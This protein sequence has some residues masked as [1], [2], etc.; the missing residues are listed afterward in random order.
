[1]LSMSDTPIDEMLPVFAGLGV[2]VAFL[3]PTP[4]GYEKAIMDA[5]A[6]VRE[7]LLDAGIHNYELQQQGPEGKVKISAHFVNL[8]DNT[9]TEASLYRP[10]TKKGDPRIWFS[11]LKTY[12]QPCNLLA[13]IVFNKELYVFNLS[14]PEIKASILYSGHAYD[15]LRS[16][17]AENEAVA[18]ELLNKIRKIHDKGFIPSITPGD[19]GVGDTLEH[20]LGISRNN[21][22]TPDYKG[23]ELKTTRLTRNGEARASTRSTL[24]TRVPDEGMTYREI[25]DNYGKWQTPR[26]E[27]EPR[28]QMYETLRVSRSNAYDLQLAV[29]ID[30]DE[31]RIMHINIEESNNADRTNQQASR[32]AN[33]VSGW[34][35]QNLR[36]ALLLKHHETFWVK[37]RSEN[38]NGIEYFSYDKVLHT[39][40]PNAT[41]LAPLIQADKITIDLAAHYKPDGKWRD[42]GV[43]FKMKP[44]DI[45]LLLG[46]PEEYDFTTS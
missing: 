6:P 24:F 16:A 10:H 17:I 15:V 37:A 30:S 7:L 46:N 18:Q 11:K 26:G 29:N 23:I 25:V 5:T 3:V 41:L 21:A 2:P 40:K 27:S 22:K 12:C 39:K 13:I 9:D 38:R 32:I 14:K 28:L 31:L 34:H 45:P 8:Y 20:E 4:T 35:L 1:M 42:H 43:L 33:Y 19:P 44:E 36:D